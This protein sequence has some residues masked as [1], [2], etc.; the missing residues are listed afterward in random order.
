V[1]LPSHSLP[2]GKTWYPLYRRLGWPEGRSG[3]VLKMLPL[4]GFDPRTIHPIASRYTGYATRPT[5][6]G[7]GN[8]ISTLT[9]SIEQGWLTYG[10]RIQKDMQKDFL[11]MQRSLLYQFFISFAHPASLYHERICERM[12]ISDCLETI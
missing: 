6:I 1:S 7:K 10:T 4:P 8:V 2:L 11:G 5:Y 3:Q 9:R 12:H